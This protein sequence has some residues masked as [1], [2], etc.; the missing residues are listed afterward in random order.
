M[1]PSAI[2]STPLD[3]SFNKSVLSDLFANYLYIYRHRNGTG[4]LITHSSQPT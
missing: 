3:L 4:S 1:G 2:P